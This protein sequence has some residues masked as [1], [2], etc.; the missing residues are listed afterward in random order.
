L[1]TSS[2]RRCP[3]ASERARAAVGYLALLA[4]AAALRWSV[5]QEIGELFARTR[6]RDRHD[7]VLGTSDIGGTAEA[8]DLLDRALPPK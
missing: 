8:R 3:P 2:R 6:L 7:G 5:P 1:P 4:A